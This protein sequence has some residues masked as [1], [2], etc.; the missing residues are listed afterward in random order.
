MP[1]PPYLPAADLEE[2]QKLK[3]VLDRQFQA[4]HVE[5]LPTSERLHWRL[6]EVN[7]GLVA[8]RAVFNLK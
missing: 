3:K 5:H 4:E 7:R 2:A 6:N 8:S 1:D